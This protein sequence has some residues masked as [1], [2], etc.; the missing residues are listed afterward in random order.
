MKIRA[1]K[2]QQRKILASITQNTGLAIP[3]RSVLDC[4]F[5]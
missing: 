4:A 1:A 2:G 3:K 5:L